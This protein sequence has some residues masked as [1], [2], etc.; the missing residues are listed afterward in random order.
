MPEPVTAFI[1]TLNEEANIAACIECVKDVDEI[2]VA[3]GG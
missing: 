2:V 1:T 3:D